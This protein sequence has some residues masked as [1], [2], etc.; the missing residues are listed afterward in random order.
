MP[1]NKQQTGGR[2]GVVGAGIAGLSAAVALRRGGWQVEVFERSLFQNE[3]GAAISVP[4]N[5]T[6]VLDRWGLDMSKAMPVPNQQSRLLRAADLTMFSHFQYPD[7]AEET[8][9]ASWS[10]HRVDLHQ[11]LRHLATTTEHQGQPVVIRLGC[12]VQSIDCESGTLEFA[13]GAKVENDLSR[14]IE[15]FT[16]H[17][18]AVQRT[19]RSV[20]RWLV[21]MDNIMADDDL[22]RHYAGELPGFVGWFDAEKNVLWVNYTCRG[23]KVL[24]NAVVHETRTGEGDRDLW[25]SP[26]SHEQVLTVLENFDPSVRRM[27]NMASEDGIKVYHLFKRPPLSSFV[28]GR[29]A[30]VGDAAHVMMPTHA[31]GCAMAVESAASIEVLFDGVKGDDQQRIK[32]RLV[33][34]DKLRLPRCNLAML[35]SNAGPQWLA[36]PGVEEEVRKFYSGPLPPVGALPWDDQFRKLLFHHDEYSAAERVLDAATGG[37]SK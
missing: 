20:Y 35:A 29:S 9:H 4:P 33:L 10:F 22:R 27:V 18:S 28:R 7:I 12:E 21:D 11:G 34:F 8:G 36:V 37:E 19:G 15:D 5:A 1:G 25:H 3:I 16:G 2:A 30:V 13:D 6:R 32:Q 26:V 23:G 31:S 14:L 24:N 17:P